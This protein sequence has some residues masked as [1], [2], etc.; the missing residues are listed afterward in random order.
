MN[1]EKI[2]EIKKY[3]KRSKGNS[4]LIKHLKGERLTYKEA[5]LA[6]CADCMYNY[7]DGLLGCG[8]TDCPLYQYMPYKNNK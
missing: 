4:L 2:L 5:V 7:E 6:K 1:E 3:G 8:I